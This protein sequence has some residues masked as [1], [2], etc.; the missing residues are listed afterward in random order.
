VNKV[1]CIG[2]ALGV[3]IHSSKLARTIVPLSPSR[4]ARASL[5]QFPT[6]A[7][8]FYLYLCRLGALLHA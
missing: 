1:L 2:E 4:C 8:G 6:R 5:A 7:E 3:V